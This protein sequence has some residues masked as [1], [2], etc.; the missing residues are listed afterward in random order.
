MIESY[1][2][3]NSDL[4]AII[5]PPEGGRIA[6]LRSMESGVEFLT[7]SERS[8]A[9]VQTGL[10]TPFLDGPC[11]GVEECLPTVA[12]CGPDT[13]GGAVPD[14]GD[15][16]QLAWQVISSSDSDIEIE[17]KG[18]SRPLMFSKRISLDGSEL[19]IDYRVQN[20]APEDTSFLYACHPLFAVSPGDRIVLPPEVRSLSLDYSRHERLGRRGA[21]ISWPRSQSGLELDVVDAP[22][23]GIAEMLY[24]SSLKEGWCGIYRSAERQG[25]KITFDT[26]QLGY[27]G[28]WL[29]YGGWPD[30][31]AKPRQYAVALEPATAP[32]NGLAGAIDRGMAMTLG[33][34]KDFSWNLR[35][36]VSKSD[37]LFSD[38]CHG[39]G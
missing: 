35:F 15:F 14:H 13:P 36:Q 1:R 17:A 23:S 6:S 7:Q 22:T 32:C 29:C 8:G 37:A 24:T 33:G 38:F 5:V 34:G 2:L 3:E 27:L 30:D 16:W 21:E 19:C 11:A 26:R 28:I 20:L 12:R 31:S 4:S 25:V 39:A 18:F 10:D 9:Y